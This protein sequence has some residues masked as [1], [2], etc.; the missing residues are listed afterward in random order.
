MPAN[1]E[2]FS[3]AIHDESLAMIDFSKV[4]RIKKTGQAGG[5]VGGMVWARIVA[6]EHECHECHELGVGNGTD[7]KHGTYE[8]GAE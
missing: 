7:G 1:R 6:S 4:H 5:R 3:R 8:G 2:L